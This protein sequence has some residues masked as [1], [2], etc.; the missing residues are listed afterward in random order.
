MCPACDGRQIRAVMHGRRRP[1][2][3][4]HRNL[5]SLSVWLTM[6]SAPLGCPCLRSSWWRKALSWMGI[7]GAALTACMPALLTICRAFAEDFLAIV[8]GM[9]SCGIRPTLPSIWVIQDLVNI[10][11]V[12]GLEVCSGVRDRSESLLQ[13]SSRNSLL[14]V[15]TPGSMNDL[16]FPFAALHWNRGISLMAQASSRSTVELDGNT[17]H[18]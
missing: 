7:S 3:T 1:E 12:G 16:V 17:S 8:A 5:S 18:G 9:A 15:Y 4:C 2:A 14:L 6:V 13:S 11:I 10:A